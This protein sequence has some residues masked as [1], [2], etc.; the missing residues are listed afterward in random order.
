[1]EYSHPVPDAFSEFPGLDGDGCDPAAVREPDRP[2]GDRATAADADRTVRTADGLETALA[3]AGPGSVLWVPGDET[4]DVTGLSSLGPAAGVTVASDR[5]LDGS[6]GALL[7]VRH[8]GEP[9][10]RPRP[11]LDLREEGARVTGLRFEAPETDFADHVWWKEGS[12]VR[13]DADGVEVDCSAFRGWGHAGVEVGREGP[14]ARTH[15]HHNAFVDNALRSLGYGVVVFHGDPL[16]R[17]N[18]FD[19]NRHAVACDG[20]D[21]AAYV[22]RDN[23]CGPRTYGHVFDM[24]RA[25]EVSADAG[26]QAGRRIDVLDNVVMAR[27][28]NDG[29]P[30][31]GVF[32]RG[33]PLDGG[34]IAGNQFAHPPTS[35]PTGRAG[36]AYRLAVGDAEAAGFD[37]SDNE[38]GVSEP[39]PR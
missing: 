15:V 16:I 37:V 18:Y 11:L 10:E 7:R 19:N 28:D 4:L 31:T 29:D 32:V 21:D 25:G 35:R 3:D 2:C 8:P 39:R 14:V 22:A 6:D 24:H 33:Q 17:S 23:F 1:M 38:F 27:T 9:D 36:E 26:A 34:R 5:G 13:V 20:Y 30:V 12:A